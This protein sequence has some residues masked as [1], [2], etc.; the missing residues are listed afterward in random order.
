MSPFKFLSERVTDEK[1]KIIRLNTYDDYKNDYWWKRNG[2]FLRIFTLLFQTD[3]VSQ[4]IHVSKIARHK[5]NR[6]KQK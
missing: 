6:H 1:W 5:T 3:R 2:D 4:L